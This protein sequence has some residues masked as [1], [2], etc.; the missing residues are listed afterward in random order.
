MYPM[1][2]PPILLSRFYFFLN[3][4]YDEAL[5]LLIQALRFIRDPEGLLLMSFM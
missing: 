2:L 5:A 3:E 1:I 4:D